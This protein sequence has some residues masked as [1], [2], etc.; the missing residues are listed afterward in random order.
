MQT[1]LD[2]VSTFA[3]KENIVEDKDSEE[4]EKF[5]NAMDNDLNTSVALS[6]L[7]D[8]ASKANSAKANGDKVLAGK[9]VGTLKM[10]MGV[11]GFTCKKSQMSEEE[12]NNRLETIKDKL[13]F[14][15]DKSLGGYALIDKVIE[16]RANARA[17]KNWD[18]A[19]KIR[20][21]FDEIGIIFK[22]GKD[23]TIWL[24]KE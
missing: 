14:V 24:E 19:D 18:L 4:V 22:D 11:L 20:N 21:T 1:A 3:G 12:L 13:D 10:L 23:K 17:A 6:V 5:K 2:E 7:F 16:I 15:E 8:L 9:F